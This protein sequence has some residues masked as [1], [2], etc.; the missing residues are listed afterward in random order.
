MKRLKKSCLSSM[1]SFDFHDLLNKLYA[2][3]KKAGQVVCAFVDEFA[4][5]LNHLWSD[6]A[7]QRTK[8][9]ALW[10]KNLARAKAEWET[11]KNLYRAKHRTGPKALT[12]DEEVA[13][14]RREVKNHRFVYPLIGGFALSVIA[15]AG[16]AY[17]ANQLHVH[18]PDGRE[19]MINVQPGTPAGR[20]PSL[21]KAQ[22]V[23]VNSLFFRLSLRLTGADR[24]LKTGYYKIDPNE[25]VLQLTE[26]L[27]QGDAVLLS[28][29]I[30]DGS[31][32]W[33]VLKT[34]NATDG[35]KH[36]SAQMSADA[37]LLAI[38][39]KEKHL[40]GLFAPD[41]YHFHA[42][43]SDLEILKAA[44]EHQQAILT[45]EWSNRGKNCVVKSPY[46]ALILAS[47]VEREAARSEDRFI[48]AGI[49]SNRL[50]IKMP[51]Q[52]DPSV[53]YGEGE[54]FEGRLRRKHL[55]RNTPYNTYRFV[56]LPPTPIGNP[57]QESIHAV[58]HP[59]KTD[60]LYFINK[61][62]GDLVASKTLQEHNRAVNR[63][64]RNSGK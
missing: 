46:E 13:I 24:N 11:T 21:L 28:W 49:F 62:N 36:D 5:R 27:A 6:R 32:Y 59:A 39:A 35:L 25:T 2:Y 14:L 47:I 4:S 43:V 10:K 15:L 57:T 64:I 37:I 8:I 50:R 63:Y 52:T 58:M 3:L 51:L 31:T 54:N 61:E 34:L 7:R 17:Y 48:V 30:A 1:R 20:I 40:E 55:D 42:G 33:E 26:R 56:G 45:Y 18:N 53:I 38:G 29:R 23:E 44:Y 22:G 60:Y 9:E 19:I 41:T 16:F 12:R